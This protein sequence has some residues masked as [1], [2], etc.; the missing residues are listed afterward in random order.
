MNVEDVK[1]ECDE[2]GFELHLIVDDGMMVLERSIVD[3]VLILNVQ[4]VAEQ[5]YDQ[6][7]MVIGPWLQ[8]RDDAAREYR[9]GIADD[10]TQQPVL[11]RV[12]GRCSVCGGEGCEFC[13]AA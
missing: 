7:K 9:T 3:G 1:I 12:L 4:A 6:A 5:L 11:D 13:P 10:P 8:E 2:R